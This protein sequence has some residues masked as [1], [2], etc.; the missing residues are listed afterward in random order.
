M[1]TLVIIC[2]KSPNDKLFTC[3]DLLYKIQ[4]K[5]NLENYKICVVDSDSD[6]FTNYEVIKNNFPDVDIYYAKNKNYEY[7]AWK[8]AAELCP[9]YDAY[10]CIQ[11]TMH[12][13]RQIDISVINDKNVY[14][15][16]N[17]SGYYSHPSIK[18]MGIDNLKTA[19]LNYEPF[20]DSGFALSFGCIFIVNYNTIKNIFETFRVPPINKDG[21]CM[22]ERNFGLYFIINN[23]TT[24]DLSGYLDKIYGQRRY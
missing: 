2:S 10:F 11:D 24:M 15:W 8:Y 16:H 3:I 17:N 18:Q 19:G 1:R 21:S 4:I 23:I 20:I 9:S 13:R 7:G 12:I 14:T 6:N 5:D 22:Y